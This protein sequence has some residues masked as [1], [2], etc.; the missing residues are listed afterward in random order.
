MIKKQYKSGF[1]LLETIV[2]GA[3][4]SGSVLV[5]AATCARSL[6]ATKINRQYEVAEQL[7]EKQL[8]LIDF[9][10]IETFIESKQMEG[11]FANFQPRYHWEAATQSVGIDNL[12]QLK[13]TVSWIEQVRKFSVSATTRINGTGKIIITAEQ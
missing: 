2:A 9:I 13:V 11:D 6:R 4:L 5:M 10:G 8:V 3:I 1:T 7:A 12:Y